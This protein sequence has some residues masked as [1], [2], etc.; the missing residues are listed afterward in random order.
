MFYQTITMIICSMSK[1]LTSKGETSLCAVQHHKFSN[2][3]KARCQT[4]MVLLLHPFSH[5]GR[6]LPPWSSSQRRSTDSRILLLPSL[7]H[8]IMCSSWRRKEAHLKS[9]LCCSMARSAANDAPLLS[10]DDDIFATF[11]A[12]IW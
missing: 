6:A 7:E 10:G 12:F 11:S 9:I 8:K 3:M 2:C 1:M 4:R 5:K